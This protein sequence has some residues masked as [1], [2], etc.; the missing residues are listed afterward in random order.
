MVKKYE[1]HFHSSGNFSICICVFPP[2]DSMCGQ[3]RRVFFLAM[4]TP[5]VL[6]NDSMLLKDPRIELQ[7]VLNSSQKATE[8]HVKYF[9][10]KC[11]YDLMA[12]H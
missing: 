4:N 10:L 1:C 9:T 8:T 7:N 6:P 11:G 2:H 3:I 5:S 12:L